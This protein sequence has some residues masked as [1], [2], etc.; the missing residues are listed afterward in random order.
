VALFAVA[1][2][3]QHRGYERGEVTTGGLVFTLA[4][5]VVLTVGGWLGGAIVFVHGVR[6]LAADNDTEASESTAT[7]RR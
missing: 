6:V 1:A 2:W 3:L 4:G 7:S 5:A